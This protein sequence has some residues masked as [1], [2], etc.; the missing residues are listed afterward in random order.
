MDTILAYLKNLYSQLKDLFVGMTPGSRIIAVLLVAVLGTSFC[1]LIIPP[2]TTSPSGKYVFLYNSREF[3][4]IEQLAVANALA[5]SGLSDYTWIE[6]KLQVKKV[7]QHKYAL[8]IAKEKAIRDIGSATSDMISS[9]SPWDPAKVMGEK[10][11]VAAQTDAARMIELLDEIETATVQAGERVAMDDKFWIKK[12]IVTAAV[13]VIPVS[14]RP[15]TDELVSTITAIVR[16]T[17][18]IADIK[19]ISITDARTGLSYQGSDEYLIGAAR[20]YLGEKEKYEREWR[21]KLDALLNYIPGAIVNVDVDLTKN[22]EERSLVIDHEKSVAIIN[23]QVKTMEAKSEGVSRAFRP[24][25]VAQQ[26][27]PLPLTMNN[28]GSG[29]KSSESLDET[30]RTMAPRGRETTITV[31]PFTPTSIRATV[32]IPRGYIRKVAMDRIAKTQVAA[33]QPPQ[34]LTDTYLATIEADI[35]ANV[36]KTVTNQVGIYKEASPIELAEQVTTIVYDDM[37]TP[38]PSPMTFWGELAQWINREWQT[39]TLIGFIGAGLLVLWSVTRPVRPE[40]IV[41]Y[42]S[43]DLPMPTPEELAALDDQEES[44]SQKKWQ[45]TL[46]S[47]D[48]GARSLQEEVFELVEEN[49]DAAAAVLRQWIGTVVPVPES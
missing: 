35:L 15:I 13:T 1:F 47:F 29:G 19:E 33:G 14:T 40:P 20:N 34:E 5:K 7:D 24:G 6:M 30:T 11:R 4:Q 2:T 43:P 37:P 16:S 9:L 45:R 23:E 44:A 27:T 28:A 32:Q 26:N 39:M 48:K 17:L 36:Q 42:E 18:A 12:K 46:N 31:A 10:A 8:A 22:S 41:I 49:P 25:Y 21:K 38:P 3:T